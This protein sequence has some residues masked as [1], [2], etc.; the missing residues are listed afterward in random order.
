[1]IH[2]RQCNG[3]E[4]IEVLVAG[5]ALRRRRNMHADDRGQSPLTRR[6]TV[7]TSAS[8]GNRIVGKFSRRPG[9]GAAVAGIALGRRHYV[10]RR[11]LQRLLRDKA[12]VVAGGTLT[13]QTRMVHHSWIPG[14][15]ATRVAN[16]ALCTSRN[17]PI[18]SAKGIG[19]IVITVMAIFASSGSTDVAHR[20]R[21]EC[22]RVVATIALAG[23]RDM[24]DG[25]SQC[26]FAIVA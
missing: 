9:C 16:V 4:R 1:M 3:L 10:G 23:S 7:V 25:Q 6:V 19:K 5:I 2:F 18:S 13:T 20:H 24:V 12:T 11:L 22:C 15:E 17:V 14:R 8:N 21:R 26:V